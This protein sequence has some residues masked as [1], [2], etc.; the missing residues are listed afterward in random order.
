MFRVHIRHL[1][2]KVWFAATATL[3][4]SFFAF[5]AAAGTGRRH[6]AEWIERARRQLDYGTLI[7]SAEFPE[8]ACQSHVRGSRRLN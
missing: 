8:L 3:I 5:G 7:E 2:A 1:P 6:N 4:F